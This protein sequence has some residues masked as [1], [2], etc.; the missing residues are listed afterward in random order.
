[1]SDYLIKTLAKKGGF[2]KYKPG[3]SYN[4]SNTGITLLAKIIEI[5][6]KK[7]FKNYTKEIILEPLNMSSSFWELKN[8]PKERHTAYYN[9]LKNKIP[10]YYIITYPDG[11]LYSSITDMTKYTQEM[12]KGYHGNSKILSKKS[13]REMMSIQFKEVKSNE[14]LCWD[15]SFKGLIGHSGN[16]FGTATLMYFSPKTKT[17][18]ILFANN[19]IETEEQENAFYEIFNTL[20]KYNFK[21]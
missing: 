9:E 7:N 20:F 1:M 11:G 17:G 2:T 14:G 13:F 18:R 3:T 10:N 6:T 8:V 5:K 4:Y 15:L 16:D 19:S 12:I 21:E